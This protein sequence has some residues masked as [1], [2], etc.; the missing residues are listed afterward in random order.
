M[1]VCVN[2]LVFKTLHSVERDFLQVN[3][4][5]ST[6]HQSAQL[7]CWD[8]KTER[9]LL[10]QKIERRRFF[11][12]SIFVWS[13]SLLSHINLL[14]SLLQ[15]KW[16]RPLPPLISIKHSG[17]HHCETVSVQTEKK[18]SFPLFYVA[19]MASSIPPTQLSDQ[20]LRRRA[21]GRLKHSLNLLFSPV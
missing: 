6:W 15:N 14:G 1:C 18:I 12:V 17:G 13:C 9:M 11:H 7:E 4:R 20:A 10:S 16:I 3:P 21:T 2:S 5:F 19:S 8:K